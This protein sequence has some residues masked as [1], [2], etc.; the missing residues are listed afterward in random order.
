ML[1]CSD[2]VPDS[3]R[4]TKGRG[5][6]RQAAREY[7]TTKNLDGDTDPWS[8]DRRGN[9]RRDRSVKGGKKRKGPLWLMKIRERV[10]E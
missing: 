3:E 2:V 7:P 9:G 5:G 1:G 10:D 6:S 4:I 8:W